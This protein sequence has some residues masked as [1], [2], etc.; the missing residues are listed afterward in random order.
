LKLGQLYLQGGAWAG[1]QIVSHEW[2]DASFRPSTETDWSGSRYGFQWWMY[3]YSQASSSS[4][5]YGLIAASG[6]GGQ[7]LFLVP[8]LDLAVVFFGCTT[9]G[10]D[11]GISDTVP[12]AVMYYYILPAVQ[13]G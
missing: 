13:G 3:R 7:K 11:C 5:P 8:E 1:Q 2:I 9:E 6:F 10:Y 12:E 4:V